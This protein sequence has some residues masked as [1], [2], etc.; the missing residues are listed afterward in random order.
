[1]IAI[2]PLTLP[3]SIPHAAAPAGSPPAG[4]LLLAAALALALG[5]CASMDEPAGAPDVAPAVPGQ[6]RPD[7]SVR[8]DT[9]DARV[10]Q[11]WSAA[12]QSV[13]QGAT[14]EALEHLYAAL[15]LD[16]ENALLWSRAAELQM[17][18]SEPSIAETFAIKSNAFAIDNRALLYRNW[19]IIEHARTMRGDLLGIRSAH[20]RVQQYQYQ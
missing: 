2:R 4:R 5:G 20:R 18:R 19:L 14:D 17:D 9:E 10:A 12:E 11:L 16:Q 6:A 8:I 7:G 15:E 3:R 1:M 13:S